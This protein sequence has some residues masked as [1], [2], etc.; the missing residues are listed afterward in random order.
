MPRCISDIGKEI[1]RFRKCTVVPAI[2]IIKEVLDFRQ[3]SLCGLAN[4]DGEW[5]LVCLAFSLRRLHTL[6]MAHALY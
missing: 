4:A 3:L 1:Y 5:C 6:F 2:G